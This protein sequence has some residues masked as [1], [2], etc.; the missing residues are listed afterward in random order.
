M[1]RMP[2]IALFLLTDGKSTGFEAMKTGAT[3]ADDRQL[4]SVA[5]AFSAPVGGRFVAILA[6]ISLVLGIAIEVQN[7]CERSLR[8]PK[9][10]NNAAISRGNA[11][12]AAATFKNPNDSG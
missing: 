4:G 7:L 2:T 10:Q 5:T 11:A 6:A 12:T 8:S 3:V 1:W 9:R